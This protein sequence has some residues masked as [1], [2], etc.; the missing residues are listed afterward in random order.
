MTRVFLT[1]MGRSGTSLLD[2]LL[3]M[4]DAIDIIS[5]P[6]P[7][8]FIEAKKQFLSKFGKPGYYVL[9]DDEVSR[10]YSVNEFKSFLTSLGWSSLHV[11]HLFEKMRSYSGQKT[12]TD[13][14]P[15]SGLAED[16]TGFA[17]VLKCCL[18]HFS[19]KDS[20]SH[21]GTKEIMCEEF[22]PYLISEG[23]RCIVIVRDPRDM[24]ASANYPLAE[25]YLGDR[26]PSLLLLQAWRKSVEFAWSL[27]N[28]P[29]FHCLRYEDLVADPLTEINRIADFLRLPQFND[30][31]LSGE[32]RDRQ[33]R[34]WAANSSTGKLGAFISTASVGAFV[35]ILKPEEIAYTEA[36]CG[37]EMDWLGYS[38]K[39]GGNAFEIIENFRDSGVISTSHLPADLSGCPKSVKQELQRLH[40]FKNHYICR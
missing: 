8:V 38:R 4:H 10:N 2:K 14:F 9:N 20:A 22:L 26:K 16:L 3:C 13:Q 11:A 24:L 5:Q 29:G 18:Q 21:I 19:F 6:I 35:R 27:R 7:L 31:L 12:P 25:K 1:G 23:Y 37:Y 40:D 30:A 17:N 34:P 39:S 33:G 28:E 36:V 15:A 32:V